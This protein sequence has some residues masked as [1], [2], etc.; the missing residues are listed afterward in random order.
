MAWVLCPYIEESNKFMVIRP[1]ETPQLIMPTTPSVLVPNDIFN[2]QKTDYERPLLFLGEQPGLLDSINKYYPDIWDLYKK[3]KKL[4]WDENEFNFSPCLAE[5]KSCT[6]DSYEIMIRTLTWQWEA[7]SVASRSISTLFAPFV[8]SSELW[9]LYLEITKNEAVHA[10]T[11]SE[12]VRASFENPNEV[13]KDVLAQQEPLQRLSIVSQIFHEASVAGRQY[14][15]GIRPNDDSLYDVVFMLVVALFCL[16]RI[17]FMA[18]FAITFTFGNAGQFLQPAKAVQKIC[19]DE[20]EV[21][22]KTGEKVLLN[23]LST[24]RGIAAMRRLAPRIKRVIDEVVLSEYDWLEHLFMGGVELTGGNKEKYIATTNY[25]AAPVYQLFGF[26]PD[27]NVPKK[28]PI[29]F[30]ADWINIGAFQP[31]PQEEKNGQYFLGGIV[32]TAANKTYDVD[33]L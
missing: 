7:D 13:L 4:D 29:G 32:D 17:Q 19:Q 20:Y 27:F 5:F 15:D 18:S 21:H 33:D 2:T 31:A 8:S 24:P 9:C 22:A 23:E 25:F 11:Y 14:Q 6:R 30:L 12:I 16:E 1:I 10:L 28:I 3:M 26:T